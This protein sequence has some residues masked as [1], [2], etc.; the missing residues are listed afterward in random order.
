[1][2]KSNDKRNAPGPSTA[3][4]GKDRQTVRSIS[5]GAKSAAPADT[6]QLEWF[7]QG[8]HLFHA[9]QFQQAR[10][11]FQAAMKGPDRAVT[12]RAGLHAGICERRLAPGLELRTAEEHYNYAITLMNSRD[13][14][15]AQKHLRTALEIEPAA[16]YVLYALTACQ[17]LAGDSQAAYEN[18]KRAIDL[19]PRN[20]LAARQDPDFAAAVNQP[21]FNRL[22]YPDKKA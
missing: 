16:D 7:E 11:A 6:T 8:M 19:Q 1:M 9:R 15:I 4:D 12:H 10:E 13:V 20:R 17:T 21:A 5:V 2:P 14:A 22:L 18:L 3:R